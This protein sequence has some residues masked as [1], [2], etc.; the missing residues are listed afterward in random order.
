MHDL[1]ASVVAVVAAF[2]IRFELAGLEQRWKLLLPLLPPFLLYAI[3]VFTIFGLFKTKWRFTSL[4][5]LVNIVKV[6]TVLAMTLLAVDYVMVAPNIL[7]TFLFGKITIALYWFLQ[8]FFLAGSRIAYRY[9]RYTRTLERARRRGDVAPALVLGRAADAEGLLRGI[10]SGAV[11]KIQVIGILSQSWADRGQSLRGI[12]VLGDFSDLERVVKDLG[13]RGTVITRLVMTPEAFAPE[14]ISLI[15]T[16]QY[17]DEVSHK[18]GHGQLLVRLFRSNSRGLMDM[19]L[20]VDSGKNAGQE[21]RIPGKKFIIGRGDD[22]QLRA[23]SDMVS[24]HHCQLVVEDSYAAVRDLGSKNGTFV[25]GEQIS[26]EVQLKP[27]DKLKVGP[28]EF[29]IV[30]AAGL[31]GKKHPPVKGVRQRRPARPTA[32]ATP[33]KTSRNG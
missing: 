21:I 33:R 26:G 13:E 11:R 19:K 5:D 27:G 18:H 6:S 1:L 22:C 9:F 2:Y 32:R 3:G 15:L 29:E 10:E 16:K 4:P 17:V 28:L 8:V 7:G 12:P 25:N 14:M 24:R 30:L 20:R 31:T 23:G